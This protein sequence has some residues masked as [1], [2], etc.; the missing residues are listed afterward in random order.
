MQVQLADAV[1]L[2][3]SPHI[4]ETRSLVENSITFGRLQE[5]TFNTWPFKFAA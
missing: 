4:N 3:T 2:R 1:T 5:E